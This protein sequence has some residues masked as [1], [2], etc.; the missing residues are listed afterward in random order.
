MAMPQIQYP[1]KFVYLVLHFFFKTAF[2]IFFIIMKNMSKT[3]KP[4]FPNRVYLERL[5]SILVFCGPLP[6]WTSGSIQ[7]TAQSFS[8]LFLLLIYLSIY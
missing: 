1:G 7:R 4:V 6:Y 8:P 5:A 3:P 2:K